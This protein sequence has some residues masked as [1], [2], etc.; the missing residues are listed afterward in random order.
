MRK[1]VLVL[2]WLTAA[3]PVWAQSDPPT[4]QQLMQQNDATIQNSNN[5]LYRSLTQQQ[6]GQAEQ[7]RRQDQLFNPAYGVTPY[8]AYMRPL[9]PTPP[10]K[11]PPKPTQPSD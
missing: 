1:M 3:A 2:A 6:I 5:A 9:K 7:Q 4:P 11:T 10:P 8:P